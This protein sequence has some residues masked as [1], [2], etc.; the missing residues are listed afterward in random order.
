MPRRETTRHC[1]L[2]EERLHRPLRV[3]LEENLNLT[4]LLW[5]HIP[6]YKKKKNMSK[7][8]LGPPGRCGSVGWSA[9]PC[10]KK[11]WVPSAVRA[12]TPGRRFN[13]R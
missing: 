7:D 6:I 3:F 11:L 4:K 9:V 10:T 12:H 1:L 2:P 8:A 5:S 13:P